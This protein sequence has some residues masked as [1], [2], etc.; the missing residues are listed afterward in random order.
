MIRFRSMESALRCVERFYVK[1][2]EGRRYLLEHAQPAIPYSLL[3]FKQL[4]DYCWLLVEKD[5]GHSL[6]PVPTNE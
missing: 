1:C 5:V 6:L 4:N 3:G 2:S